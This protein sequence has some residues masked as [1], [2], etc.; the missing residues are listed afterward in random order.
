MGDPQRQPPPASLN[1]PTVSALAPG[2]LSFLKYLKDIYTP[3]QNEAEAKQ[4]GK[5]L[6]SHLTNRLTVSVKASQ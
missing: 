2:L 6:E 4:A 5:T 1:T 3:V